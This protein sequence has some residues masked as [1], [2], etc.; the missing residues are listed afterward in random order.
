MDNYCIKNELITQLKNEGYKVFGL[1][2]KVERDYVFIYTPNNNL[3][4][5]SQDTFSAYH[6]S[7]QYKPSRKNGSGCSSREYWDSCK[8]VEDIK[9]AEIEN[10]IFASTFK[11][12]I[13]KYKNFNEWY[14][15]YWD[16]DN[17]IEL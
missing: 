11:E 5:V 6:I 3:L 13:T 4:F 17:L 9:N 7:L 8:T 16:K 2:P 15:S 12:K 10:S 14:K 1:K